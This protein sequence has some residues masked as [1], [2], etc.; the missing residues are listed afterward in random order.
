LRFVPDNEL[1]LGFPNAF[2]ISK[3]CFALAKHPK[4]DLNFYKPQ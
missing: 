2:D 3:A 4:T 1:L